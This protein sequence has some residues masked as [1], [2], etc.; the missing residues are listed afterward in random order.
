MIFAVSQV[1]DKFKEQNL[2][3]YA[4]FIDLTKTFDPVNREGLWA[5]LERFSCPRKFMNLTCLLHA[6]MKGLVLS[7]GETSDTFAELVA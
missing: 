3:L 6:N 5:I 1:Q 4:G 2:G 7:T